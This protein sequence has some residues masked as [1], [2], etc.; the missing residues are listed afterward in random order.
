MGD[1]EKLTINFAW[2]NIGNVMASTTW[3]LK[4]QPGYNHTL[5]Y[6]LDLT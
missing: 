5:D 6:T 2:P 3:H 4:W 1:N